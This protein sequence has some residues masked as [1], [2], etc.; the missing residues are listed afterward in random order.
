MQGWQ[1]DSV[2]SAQASVSDLVTGKTHDLGL[3]SASVTRP[4]GVNLF[5]YGASSDLVHLT[6]PVKKL[7]EKRL[8]DSCVD[9][10]N[11]AVLNNL[12]FFGWEPKR[13]KP[14]GDEDESG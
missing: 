5:P 6:D 2:L 13:T 4:R 12:E 8:I 1:W 3:I 7:M 14:G 9:Q 11:E 10:F